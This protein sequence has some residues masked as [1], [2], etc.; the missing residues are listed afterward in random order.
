MARAE[1]IFGEDISRILERYPNV[2]ETYLEFAQEDPQLAELPFKEVGEIEFYGEKIRAYT[3]PN[4]IQHQ[5]EVIERFLPEMEQ[6]LQ[7][8]GAF[9][10]VKRENIAK[11]IIERT[12]L[13]SHEVLSDWEFWGFIRFGNET[14]STRHL[15]TYA[16]GDEVFILLDPILMRAQSESYRLRQSYSDEQEELLSLIDHFNWQFLFGDK[17]EQVKIIH[18]LAHTEGVRRAL[19]ELW[20][21]NDRVPQVWFDEASWNWE[22]LW[23][24]NPGG[25]SEFFGV[26]VYSE[27][28][29]VS[30]GLGSANPKRLWWVYED[31]WKIYSYQDYSDR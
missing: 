21:E 9:Y 26:G 5:D 11:E 1:S 16:R 10:I 22:K 25:E 27:W 24:E 31:G 29:D 19:L 15:L 30:S 8:N 3:I 28:R 4:I 14:F 23:R 13:S 2:T 7:R 6:A 12:D 20:V 18:R 17:D